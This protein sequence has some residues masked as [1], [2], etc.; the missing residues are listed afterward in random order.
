MWP[1]CND[2]LYECVLESFKLIAKEGGNARPYYGTCGGAYLY[3]FL[4]TSVGLITKVENVVTKEEIDLT[5]Y[6]SL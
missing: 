6:E 1:G 3:K 4:P 5:D 2:E